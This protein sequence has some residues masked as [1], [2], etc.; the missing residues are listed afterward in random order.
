MLSNQQ[1][2]FGASLNGRLPET[3]VLAQ[4]VNLS[5]R[6]NWAISAQQMP[7]F[8][9]DTQSIQDHTPSTNEATSSGSLPALTYGTRRARL[10]ESPTGR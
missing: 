5:G 1:L 8:F 9:Y 4:Y 3:Q 7:Y 10:V 2:I 6:L